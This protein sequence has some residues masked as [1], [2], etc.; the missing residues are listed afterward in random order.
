M[1]TQNNEEGRKEGWQEGRKEGGERRARERQMM[2][3]KK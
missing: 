2:D 3:F 1:E